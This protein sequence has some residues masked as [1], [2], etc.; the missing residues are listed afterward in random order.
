[1]LSNALDMHQNEF[2]ISLLEHN[3]P[4]FVCTGTPTTLGG[5]L[6][7]RAAGDNHMHADTPHN[8]MDEQVEIKVLLDRFL[9]V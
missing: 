8:H 5:G 4:F 1:M 2:H 6:V 9:Q 7:S 3:F